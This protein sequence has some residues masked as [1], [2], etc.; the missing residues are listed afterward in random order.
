MAYVLFTKVSA[1]S[2][3]PAM[4]LWVVSAQGGDPRKLDI[5]LPL[6][7]D[8]RV[9]PDGQRIAFTAGEDQ[10]EVWEIA[11]LGVGKGGR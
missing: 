3:K 4:A 6:L 2:G 8:L 1:S 11:N 10:Q 9:S 5:T 7:R